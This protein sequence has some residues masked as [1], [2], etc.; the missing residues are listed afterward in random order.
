MKT[1]T[2][3][4]T[5]LLFFA[6]ACSDAE[7]DVPMEGQEDG[8]PE[9]VVEYNMT[10]GLVASINGRSDASY[11]PEFNKKVLVS[12]RMFPDD[13]A[14]TGFDLYRRS[15]DGEE[16]KLNE[17]PIVTSTNFQDL[18]A[19]LN[20]DNTYC[21]CAANSVETLDTY[22]LTAAQ[23][24]VGLP[25]ISI[26][27]KSGLGVVDGWDFQANDASIGDVDGDGKYEIILKRLGTK[28]S[29]SGDGKAENDSPYHTTLIEAYRMDGTFLWRV[30]LGPNIIG[31]NTT[32]IAVYDFDGD[33][34]AEVATRTSEGTVFGDGTEIGDTNN[35]GKTD[36]RQPG[37]NYIPGGPSFLS[38]IDG[39]TGRE[40]ARADYIEPGQSEDWGDN[41]W[42]RAGSIRVAVGYFSGSRPSVL[43]CRGVY[44]KSVL[45]AWDFKNG[46]TLT[47]RWRFDSS[48]PEYEG[49]SGQG[50]HSLCVGDVD[51][52]GC[53][54]VV[55]GGM[56]VDHDGKGLWNSKHGHGDAMHLGKF[57]PSREGLQIW[58]CFE[59]CPFDV[60]A[61]LRDAKTGE[62]IWD[63]K[64]HG[65]MGR[66][67]VADID[68]DSPGCEMWW[69]Q[70]NVHSVT[71]EDLGYGAKGYNMAIWFDGTLNRQL[72]DRGT[73]DAPQ[74]EKGRV[75][76]VYRYN[77]VTI[78]SSK[79]NPCFYG[80]IWGD[81]R[82]ELIQVSNDFTELRVFTTWYP[83]QYKFPY[84]MSDH[85]YRM[86]ALN[87]NI[88]YNMPTQLGYYLGSDLDKKQE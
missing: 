26:P 47:K 51:G 48:L 60:A 57:D 72:Y 84:L 40:L 46:N 23:A 2:F 62:T 79:S 58:S 87:Q 28:I 53:D 36:Y 50:N 34:R 75:F 71:G 38:I 82:E 22:T 77:V 69:Y 16:I 7:L 35:D 11:Y 59:A 3:L 78:N 10:R 88:G 21:L 4:F 65:D 8:Q 25:Y 43:I 6:S 31:G 64:K 67:L 85:L 49:W 39:L 45:E 12:W 68:P 19:N 86:S 15:G 52:D 27:L 33:G 44:G 76:T 29:S 1:A 18:T 81:W 30:A 63:Y 54:E 42:K 32:S 9:A 56:C 70:G 5:T 66:C 55:Y 83:T 41:Y 61:A 73:I 14:K 20:A 17:E 80:D 37:M 74:S 24:S 13:N